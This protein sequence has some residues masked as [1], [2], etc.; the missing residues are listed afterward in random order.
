MSSK[1]IHFIQKIISLGTLW[2]PGTIGLAPNSATIVTLLLHVCIITCVENKLFLIAFCLYYAH[3]GEFSC[4][5]FGGWVWWLQYSTYLPLIPWHSHPLLVADANGIKYIHL[6]SY[7]S[8][9]SL[10][11]LVS[12]YVM[13]FAW[14]YT[15]YYSLSLLT[16]INLKTGSST[17]GFFMWD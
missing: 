6:L 15:I 1:S 11:F 2:G 9:S 13:L 7:M 17:T 3:I 16:N 8:L 14:K 5:W 10:F 12:P 4:K